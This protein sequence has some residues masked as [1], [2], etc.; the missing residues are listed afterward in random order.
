MD[1]SRVTGQKSLVT[2]DASLVTLDSSRVVTP[3]ASRVVPWVFD[4][5]GASYLDIYM[6]GHRTKSPGQD[7]H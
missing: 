6:H 3:D 5:D 4:Q 7:N 2:L 1:A